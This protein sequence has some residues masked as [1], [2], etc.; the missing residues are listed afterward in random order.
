[1][2]CPPKRV[3]VQTHLSKPRTRHRDRQTMLSPIRSYRTKTSDWRCFLLHDTFNKLASSYLCSSVMMVN[4]PLKSNCTSEELKIKSAS[5]S[6]LILNGKNNPM[7]T[8]ASAQL[9]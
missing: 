4:L 7:S 2:L 9:K 1:M 8:L 5:R 6:Y 3:C